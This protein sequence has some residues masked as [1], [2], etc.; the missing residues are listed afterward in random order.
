MGPFSVDILLPNLASLWSKST[1]GFIPNALVQLV[2]D[3]DQRVNL[4][5]QKWSTLEGSRGLASGIP[6]EVATLRCTS[7]DLH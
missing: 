5:G 4:G 3:G 6:D 2:C 7:T 1:P